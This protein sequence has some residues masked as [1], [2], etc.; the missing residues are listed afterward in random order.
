MVLS[1][2]LNAA[3][4]SLM[5]GWYL[6]FAEYLCIQ[7]RVAFWVLVSWFIVFLYG[8]VMATTTSVLSGMFSS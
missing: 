8:G 6:F 5:S 2:T 1:V 4:I 7:S 3:A